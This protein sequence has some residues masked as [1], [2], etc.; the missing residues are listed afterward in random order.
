MTIAIHSLDH[1]GLTVPDLEEA[2][3]FFVSVFGATELYRFGKSNDPA[4]METEIG[5]HPDASFQAAMLELTPAV[6]VELF[7]WRSE[8]QSTRMPSPSDTGGHHLCVMVDEFDQAVAAVRERTDVRVHG[9]GGTLGLGRHAG[10]RW[11]YIRTRWGLQI[12]LIGAR[13]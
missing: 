10:G 12:E 2:V 7:Q 9:E 11:I 1:V 3:A 6:Y 5:V 8:R 4:L 13:A